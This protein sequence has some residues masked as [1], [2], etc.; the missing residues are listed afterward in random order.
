MATARSTVEDGKTT[1][2]IF[3]PAG[4]KVKTDSKLIQ[5]F[6]HC[7]IPEQQSSHRKNLLLTMSSK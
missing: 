7:V 5:E 4:L 6:N 1:T 2:F 3:R